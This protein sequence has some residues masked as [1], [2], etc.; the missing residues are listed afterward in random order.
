MIVVAYDPKSDYNLSLV[1][2]DSF[3]TKDISEYKMDVS[4]DN[5]SIFINHDKRVGLN[6]TLNYTT[7]GSWDIYVNKDSKIY[8]YSN[9]DEA[10]AKFFKLLMEE[11]FVNKRVLITDFFNSYSINQCELLKWVLE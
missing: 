3:K 4:Y 1:V 2:C 8:E 11:S 6:G 10:K 7:T 9:M 5:M